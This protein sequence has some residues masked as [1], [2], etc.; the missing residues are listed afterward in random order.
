V[1]LPRAP[2]GRSAARERSPIA[3]VDGALAA[4]LLVAVE[5]QVWFGRDSTDRH[6]AVGAIAGA[7]LAML[8]A[9]RRRSPSGALLIAAF[10]A[11]AQAALGGQLVVG[12]LPTLMPTVAIIVVLAY[13]TG[14]LDPIERGGVVVAAAAAVNG[15]A[16]ML[17]AGNGPTGAGDAA[18]RLF[19]A[20][21]VAIP[22]WF[23]GTLVRTRDERATEFREL[24]ASTAA[25]QTAR[26]AMAA[27]KE[28]ARIGDELQAIV[29]HSISAM[30]VQ[31][32]G[33]RQLLT[34]DPGRARDAL[35][36]IEQQGREALSDLRR[37]LGMLRKDDDPRALTPQPG[38]EQLA[39]LA[40]AA[41][42][43]GLACDVHN[44]GPPACLTPGTDLVAYRV[45]ES[46]LA[47]AERNGATRCVV[48]VDHAPTRLMIRV[49]PNCPVA[50]DDDA[51]ASLAHRVDLYGGH[52]DVTSD[53]GM[54][55]VTL[56]IAAA[57]VA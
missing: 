19:Y 41:R 37:L 31:A 4:V 13:S 20:A 51:V 30:V 15:V 6:W 17:G 27:A 1:T 16:T 45:V 9:V 28:R 38:L 34:R 47:Q 40:D 49:E 29:T 48:T 56:P 46:A 12:A 44:V 52:V 18:G 22:A 36:A 53:Q 26:A 33:A 25:D 2:R 5:L 54:L 8:V 7:L 14:S 24:A 3:R 43:R 23:V 21:L 10:A 42:R 35:L 32:G 11:A 57:D 55:R 50:P 39:N